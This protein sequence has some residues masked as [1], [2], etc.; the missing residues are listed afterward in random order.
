MGSFAEKKKAQSLIVRE[1]SWF[2]KRQVFLQPEVWQLIAGWAV[3]Q[4]QLTTCPL[5]CMPKKW[6]YHKPKF[7][8]IFIIVLTKLEF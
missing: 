3:R 7:E 6:A 4:S 8:I 2:V 1:S 5:G